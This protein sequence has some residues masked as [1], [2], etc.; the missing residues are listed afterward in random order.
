MIIHVWTIMIDSQI[1]MTHIIFLTTL[2]NDTMHTSVLEN[3]E[4]ATTYQSF[5]IYRF[6][7]TIYIFKSITSFSV[8]VSE[9]KLFAS[10]KH[11]DGVN[12]C[13]IRAIYIIKPTNLSSTSVVDEIWPSCIRCIIILSDRV[14]L[15]LIVTE[16]TPEES[17]PY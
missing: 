16:H 5:I 6:I 2:T 17:K 14:A 11:L 13:L 7:K 4:I 8:W 1:V 12:G 15:F 9:I 10:C 3:F